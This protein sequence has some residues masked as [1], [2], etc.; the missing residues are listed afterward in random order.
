MAKLDIG[1]RQAYKISQKPYE[2]RLDLI[3]EGLPIILESAASLWNA[4]TK[5]TEN[6]REYQ[7]LEG[8][9]EEEAAKILILLDAVRCPK[10]LVSSKMGQIIKN[11]YDH[12]ARILYGEA[13]GW[14]PSNLEELR[15]YVDQERRA[16]YLDG[17]SGEHIFPNW[18]VF[19]RESLLYADLASYE[20]GPLHWNKPQGMPAELFANPYIRKPYSLKI[21]EALSALGALERRGLAIIAEVWGQLEFKTFENFENSEE[22]TR[23]MTER[24]IAD[25]LT[26]EQASNAD[27]QLLYDVWQMPMYNLDLRLLDVTL[28]ELNEERQT[29]W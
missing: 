1:L 24:L 4:A 15:R 26:S 17:D 21:A 19:K 12:L 7:I 27:V 14:K 9:A 29:V 8:L 13:Q 25:D 2:E 3:A 16:H 28:E 22:L 10:S 5:L 6:P 20:G 23:Q 11:F 18:S